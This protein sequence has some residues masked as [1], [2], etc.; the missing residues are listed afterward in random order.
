[1]S[2]RLVYIYADES[3]LGN[4]F[5]GG[6]PG[7]AAGLI[8]QFHARAGWRR[9][10]YFEFHAATTNNRMALTSA[11]LGLAWLRRSCD[12]VLTTDSRYLVSGMKEWVHGWVARGWRRKGGAIENLDLWQRLVDEASRHRVEWR[13]VRGHA[14]HAKNEYANMLAVRAAREARS[15][16]ALVDSGFPRWLEEQ[17]ERGH[18]LDYLDLPPEAP[19]RPDPG[20]AESG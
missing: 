14:G 5:E 2:D 19:F 8:E 10:D 6:N 13:W 1:M 3:C 9:K 7:A 16:G 20:P 15:S 11:I 4:Q 12:V 18:Y 17:T